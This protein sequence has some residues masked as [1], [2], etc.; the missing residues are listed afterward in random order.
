MERL[1]DR[2]SG[3][4]QQT[5]DRISRGPSMAK[6]GPSPRGRTAAGSGAGHRR[7][8]AARGGVHSSTFDVLLVG[9]PRRPWRSHGKI[10]P[11]HVPRFTRGAG[12]VAKVAHYLWLS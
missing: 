12:P 6:E 9:R 10:A 2:E 7:D 1:T 5:S 3:W 4:S 11:E 8:P